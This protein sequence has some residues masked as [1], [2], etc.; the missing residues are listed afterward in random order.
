MNIEDIEERYYNNIETTDEEI[1]ALESYIVDK[2]EKREEINDTE[3]NFMSEM[4]CEKDRKFIGE[5]RHGWVLYEYVVEAPNGKHYRFEIYCHD[6]YGWDSDDYSQ[7][8]PE[9]ELKKVVVEQWVDKE[10]G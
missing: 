10:V 6:D 5:G 7:V 3:I 4:W 9:V 2:L 8:C 1:A